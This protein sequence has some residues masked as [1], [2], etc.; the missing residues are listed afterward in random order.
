MPG[1]FFGL[2]ELG[3]RVG[4]YGYPTAFFVRPTEAVSGIDLVTNYDFSRRFFPPALA[5]TLIPQAMRAAK[6]AG[7]YRIFVLVKSKKGKVRRSA[8]TYKVC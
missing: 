7:T 1:L 3:L 2:L 4:G 5:R 6:P 8:R